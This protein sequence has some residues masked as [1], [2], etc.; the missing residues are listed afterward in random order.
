MPQALRDPMPMPTP[1]RWKRLAMIV[2]VGVGFA[3]CSDAVPEPTGKAR[4]IEPARTCR[5]C[6]A[7]YVEEWEHSVHAHASFSPIM[8]R[9]NEIGQDLSDGNMGKAEKTASAC[10]A[11]AALP[12]G[13]VEMTANR[14]A[15]WGARHREPYAAMIAQNRFELV[16]LTTARPSRGT[17]PHLG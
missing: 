17:A 11:L 13:H 2:S 8:R 12:R 1:G 10:A 14:K 4:L 5:P 7:Q 15:S 3:G 9:L 6:H 16:R